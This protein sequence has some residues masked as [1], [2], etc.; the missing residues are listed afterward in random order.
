MTEASM[1]EAAAPLRVEI[2]EVQYAQVV[3]P[4]G[5]AERPSLEAYSLRQLLELARAHPIRIVTAGG[6]VNRR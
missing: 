3:D 2:D 4:A 6:P 1:N 5:A